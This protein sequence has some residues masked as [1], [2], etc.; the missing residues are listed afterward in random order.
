MQGL[1]PN[2]DLIGFIG[3]TKVMPLLQ[4]PRNQG[5]DSVFPQH[6]RPDIDLIG[7]IGTTKVIPCYKA[8]EICCPSEF[9]RS[10]FSPCKS[11]LLQPTR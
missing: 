3:L 8:F 10:L 4:S 5:F 9:F 7:F 1:K 2:V 6:V 11:I